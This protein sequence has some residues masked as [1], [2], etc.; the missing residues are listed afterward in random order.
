MT[1]YSQKDLEDG[2]EFKILRSATGRFYDPYWL[3]R[4]LQEES[5]GG[6]D[7]AREVRQLSRPLKAPRWRPRERCRAWL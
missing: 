4:V 5:L 7:P 3:R 2:W 6:V 1:P